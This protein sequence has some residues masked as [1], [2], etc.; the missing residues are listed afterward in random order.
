MSPPRQAVPTRCRPESR[1]SREPLGRAGPGTLGGKETWSCP[2]GA[3]T[4]GVPMPTGQLAGR[5]RPRSGRG[6]GACAGLHLI[7]TGAGLPAKKRSSRSSSPRSC[8]TSRCCRSSGKECEA[9]PGNTEV[10]SCAEPA[11]WTVLLCRALA[12]PAGVEQCPWPLLTR[13][14]HPAPRPR[15]HGVQTPGVPAGRAAGWGLGPGDQRPSPPVVCGMRFCAWHVFGP[16]AGGN[17]AAAA[18]GSVGT[19]GLCRGRLCSGPRCLH[20]A[21]PSSL[22]AAWRLWKC[23]VCMVAEQAA[24]GIS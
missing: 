22:H 1:G 14:R 8:R 6:L 16:R 2:L 19:A 4:W 3:A 18:Q 20:S 23:W 11:A 9:S 5:G 24:G 10:R 7:H 12:G 17:L 13:P 21:S 15:S